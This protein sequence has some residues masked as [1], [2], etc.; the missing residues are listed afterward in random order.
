R[1][2][3]RSAHRDTGST[4]LVLAPLLLLR[5]YLGRARTGHYGKTADLFPGPQLGTILGAIT[6]GTG[7]GAGGGSWLAGWSFDLT[8]SY[9]LAFWLSIFFYVCGSAAFWLLRGP[10]S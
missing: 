1:R 2:C 9:H 3:V 5:A 4:P 6:V 10:R 8:G 7:V